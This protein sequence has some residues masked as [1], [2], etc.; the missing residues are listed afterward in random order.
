MKTEKLTHK[1]FSVLP[2]F[3]LTAGLCVTSSLQSQS[4]VYDNFEGSKVLKYGERSGVLDSNAK[5]PSPKDINASARCALYVRNGSKKFDN[6]KMRLDRN[7]TDVDK[8][9]TYLGIPPRLKMKVYTSA[10]PG[11]LVEILLGSKRGNNDYPAGTHSQYQAYTKVSNQWEELE[12]LFSQIPQGSETSA[13]QIDQVTLLFN[14]NSAN[15]DTYY[16]DEITGPPLGT[17]VT[18]S[19]TGANVQGG[20]SE[21]AAEG[22]DGDQAQEAGVQSVNTTKPVTTPAE[23]EKANKPKKSKKKKNKQE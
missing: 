20:S 13:S 3:L 15:S 6:I 4:V 5:N 14:P 19:S 23:D 18:G 21:T 16:F 7:L 12:F 17:T 2:L 9:A 22:A 8:Y 11:T 1:F 10:P